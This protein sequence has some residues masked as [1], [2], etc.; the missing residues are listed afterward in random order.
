[1]AEINW[2][3][4]YNELKAKYMNDVDVSFR[5]GCEQGMQMAQ[6]QQMQDQQAQ[7]QEMAQQQQGQPGEEGAPQ[8]QQGQDSQNPQGS[9]LDQHIS[10]LEGM[11]SKSE[12]TEDDLQTIKK[13][14]EELKFGIEMKKSDKAIVG[15][16]KA[17]APKS[18]V[19]MRSSAANNLDQKQKNALTMQE[20]IVGNIMSQWDRHESDLA[21]NINS[22]VAGAGLKK[23]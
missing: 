12:L 5:L 18:P 9:E 14:I 22:V 17:L 7:E 3:S 13:S 23:D 21:K 2:K 6:Q 1:M 8:E 19:T 11:V 15:I 4:K 20:K 16:A 10:T